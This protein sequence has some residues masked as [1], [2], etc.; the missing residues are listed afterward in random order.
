VNETITIKALP[1]VTVASMRTT[2]ANYDHFFE[3]VSKMGEYMNEV[4]VVC[5][6]P[7]YCFTIFH[8]DEY[9]EEDIDVEICEAVVAAGP[10]SDHVRFKPIPGSDAAA[11]FVHRGPYDR[12]GQSYNALF[13]W[14]EANGYAPADHVREMYIDGIWNED[15]PEQWTTEIQVPVERQNTA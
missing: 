11:C 9:R 1:D 4:G 12:L 13:S 3:I 15:D 14:I 5:R 10:D 6:D 2:V 8:N 7:A